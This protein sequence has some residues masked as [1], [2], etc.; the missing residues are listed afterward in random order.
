MKLIPILPP[1]LLQD[2]GVNK[3]ESTLQEDAYK[4]DTFYP[5]LTP[6]LSDKDC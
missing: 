6:T 1:P 4:F 3:F 2:H 5:C